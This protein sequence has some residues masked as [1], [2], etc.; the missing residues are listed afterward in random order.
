MN[1]YKYNVSSQDG[2]N[3]RHL[4]YSITEM[5]ANL[6][7]MTA[8][9]TEMT[10]ILTVPILE[11]NA[12]IP[13]IIAE[14]LLTAEMSLEAVTAIFINYCDERRAKKCHCTVSSLHIIQLT[15]FYSIHPRDTLKK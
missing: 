12:N 7:E 13:V 10:A 8:I 3:L 6:T 9:L 15:P 2:V 11:T 1:V 4:E 14:G 5:T